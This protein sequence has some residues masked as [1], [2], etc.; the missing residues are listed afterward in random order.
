MQHF[1]DVVS[2]ITDPLF[3]SAPGVQP[4][5]V[6]AADASVRVAPYPEIEDTRLV[7]ALRI[8]DTP[9]ATVGLEFPGLAR[10]LSATLEGPNAY[11]TIPSARLAA[12]ISAN[13]FLAL[14]RQPTVPTSTSSYPPG[15]APL[16][17]PAPAPAPAPVNPT[18]VAAPPV[19]GRRSVSPLQA[20][21]EYLL[22]AGIIREVVNTASAST[23]APAPAVSAAAATSDPDV[24]I[25]DDESDTETQANPQDGA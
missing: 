8:Q 25:M 2:A 22:H 23:S 4:F 15:F 10:A 7:Q 18:P 21:I 16:T 11:I 6:L 1:V 24:N 3:R 19:T 9:I 17:A 5:S 12:N 20:R 14:I 13:Q